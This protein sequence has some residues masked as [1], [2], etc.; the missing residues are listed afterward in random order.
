MNGRGLWPASAMWTS[1]PLCSAACA[2]W[3][4]KGDEETLL[5]RFSDSSEVFRR[6]SSTVAAMVDVDAL[7]RIMARSSW[8]LL[9]SPERIISNR[10]STMTVWDLKSSSL[11]LPAILRL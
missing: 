10:F 11:R 5:F 1:L 4:D 8:T 9:S 2:S 6:F 3:P 7:E